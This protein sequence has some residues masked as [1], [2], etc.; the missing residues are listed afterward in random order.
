MNSIPGENRELDALVNQPKETHKGVT[1]LALTF[2]TLL[3]SQGSDARDTWPAGPSI[4]ATVPRYA[5]LC[6]RQ[7]AGQGPALGARSDGTRC[8]QRTPSCVPG[9]AQLLGGRRLVRPA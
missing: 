2:G 4:A 8:D 7:A 3:S 1:C 9:P 6:L 5:A